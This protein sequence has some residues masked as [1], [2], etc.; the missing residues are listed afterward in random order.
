MRRQK[1]QEEREQE[2]K[3]ATFMFYAF[4]VL[5]FCIFMQGIL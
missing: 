3:I 2:H 4:I 5:I 1:T